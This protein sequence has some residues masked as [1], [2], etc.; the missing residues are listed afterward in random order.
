[1]PE[2]PEVETIAATLALSLKNQTLKQCDL[3]LS[4]LKEP[5]SLEVSMLD[6]RR[7]LNVRRRAKFLW[8][9]FDGGINLI[10]H[11]RME[12]KFHVY[13]DAREISKHTHMVWHMSE[14]TVHYLDTRKFSRFSIVED[15]YAHF[16][17]KRLGKE[18]WDPT[19][20]AAWLYERFQK[21]TRAIKAVLLD[22]TIITGI[23]NIYADEVLYDQMIHPKT[24]ANRIPLEAIAPLIESVQRILEHAIEAGGTTIRSYTSSLNVHGRFQVTLK[25]YG[26]YGMPCSRCSTK[27]DK[28]KVAGRTSVYCPK[29]QRVII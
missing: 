26:Q 20:N 29:C 1:M 7:L 13:K 11:L 15:P 10:L 18:P 2:L 17:G 16:I 8:F 22:Q 21:T 28:I 19:L 9:E 27:L 4:S 3:H 23:G 25:A 5:G 14:C 24:P 6:G 12:G